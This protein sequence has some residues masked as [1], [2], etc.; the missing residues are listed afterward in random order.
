MEYLIIAG[1]QAS[2]KTTT[3]KYLEGKCSDYPDK[4][5]IFLEETREIVNKKYS[6]FGTLT[7]T[8]DL[9]YKMIEEDLKRLNIIE[10]TEKNKDLF[11]VDETSIFT[12]A[13]STLHGIE[14]R[15]YFNEYID[16]LKKLNSKIIFI[17][18]NPEISWERR[19]EK[20][21]KRVAG[22]HEDEKKNA[23]KEF[24]TYLNCAYPELIKMFRQINLPKARITNGLIE[25]TVRYF[26]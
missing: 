26:S 15:D 4:N 21:E 13:H 14:T 9:E 7:V 11:Y 6:P 18:V 8:R 1:P 10:E 12:L 16:V 20:Y 17:D 24:R 23:M 3:K 19:K 22:M 5:F 25:N 2:G